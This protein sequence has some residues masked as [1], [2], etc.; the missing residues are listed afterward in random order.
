[1]GK[2]RKQDRH[3]Q[4]IPGGA[5]PPLPVRQP[6][7]PLIPSSR[8]N[9]VTGEP[10][11]R[12][13]HYIVVRNHAKQRFVSEHGHTE[14][15][16]DCIPPAIHRLREDTIEYRCAHDGLGAPTWTKEFRRYIREHE[17]IRPR[18]DR[19]REYLWNHWYAPEWAESELRAAFP[20]VHVDAVL[21]VKRDGAD[22]H[23]TA[24]KLQHTI[25]WLNRLVARMARHIHAILKQECLAS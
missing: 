18:A 15:Y 4:A 14:M 17:T 11:T 20:S 5:A 23:E 8:R 10:L 3:R 24:T 25:V 2:K 6:R 13:T 21:A 16:L 12:N 9:S 19:E 1:M 7:K 22:W